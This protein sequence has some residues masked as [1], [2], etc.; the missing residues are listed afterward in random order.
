MYQKKLLKGYLMVLLSGVL[1]GCMALITTHIDGKAVTRET[2]VLLRNALALPI[3]GFMAFREQKTLKI[4]LK[5]LPSIGILAV[6][7]CCVTPLLL[8]KSY[9]YIQS[10][11]ATVFHFVYPAVVVILNFLFLGK[12][13]KWNTGLAVFVCVVGICLFYDPSQPLNW[14][15]CSF[16]LISGV[17]YAI[18]ILLLSLLKKGTV[19][20][21]Q[22]SFYIGLSS[23]VVMLGYCLISGTL[24]IPSTVRDWILCAVL[25]LLI[26]AGAVVLFQQGTFIV[27]SERAAILS[28]ME[29]LTGFVIGAAFMG[30]FLGRGSSYILR[31]VLGA[32]LVI[33]ASILIA[34]FDIKDGKTTE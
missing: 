22:L 25:A 13:V 4:P 5:T 33:G 11:T 21:F 10:G 30:E 19:S 32:I 29:P 9:G 6:M 27:G 14:T 1:F 34:V 20:G 16:A 3:L 8:Y 2:V 15:G 26:N 23:T 31:S 28:T 7:G 17:T 12:G 24:T 18:Y